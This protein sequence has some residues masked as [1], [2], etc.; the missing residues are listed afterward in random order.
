VPPL[1]VLVALGRVVAPNGLDASAALVSG[2]ASLQTACILYLA[3]RCN[4]EADVP[5]RYSLTIPLGAAMFNALIC[6][7]AYRVV[8]GR[9]VSWKGR[10]Y[11]P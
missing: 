9:G 6:Y 4:R 3:W 5:G 1:I 8:S 2:V 11:S 7:S 10:M